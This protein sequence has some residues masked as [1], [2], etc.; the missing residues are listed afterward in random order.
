MAEKFKFLHKDKRP[1]KRK[2]SFGARASDKMTALMG[3]WGFIL[4]FIL[5][6]GIWVGLNGYYLTKYL[7]GKAFDP[8][9]FILLNLFLSCLA[10]IQAPI[11]LMSQNRQSETD[12]RRSEYDYAV[13]RKAEREIADMQKDLEDIKLLIRTVKKDYNLNLKTDKGVESVKRNVSDIK[14]EVKSLKKGLKK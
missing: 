14:K 3:S 12:R 5:I 6:L 10:A 9:P 7:G 1:P 13:N 11:I 4:I 2:E 8:F